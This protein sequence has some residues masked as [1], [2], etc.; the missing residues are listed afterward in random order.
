M[1]VSHRLL[2]AIQSRD[3]PALEAILADDFQHFD[4]SGASVDRQA[5]I[6]AIVDAPYDIRSIGFEAIDVA[7]IDGAGVVVGLQRAEVRMPDGELLVS[8]GGFTDVF[9]RH[10][11][12][13][14][15]RLAHSV[16]L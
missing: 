12:V 11:D 6:S 9:T 14:R 8:R 7:D 5:F 13:W 2:R 3:A 16:D 4:T 15:I 1:D 10:G